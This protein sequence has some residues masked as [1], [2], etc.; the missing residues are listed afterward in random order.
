L[1]IA[2][3]ASPL[4]CD[5]VPMMTAAAEASPAEPATGQRSSFIER[6]SVWIL[7]AIVVLGAIP[8]ARQLSSGTLYPDDAWVALTNHFGLSTSVHMLV[9]SPGFTLFTQWWTGL[10]PTT[11]WFDQLPDLVS[12]IAGIVAVYA[13]IRWNR[14]DRWVALSGAALLAVSTEATSFATHLKPY[15]DDVLLAC[16]LLYAAERC[17]RSMSSRNLAMLAAVAGAC[18]AWSFSSAIVVAGAYLMVTLVWLRRREATA[19]LVLSGTAAMAVI[20][21][22]YLGIVH[23]QTT[24]SLAHYWHEH[25]LSTSSIGS[26]LRSSR[27]AVNGVFGDQLA[28]TPHHMLHLVGRIDEWVLLGLAIAGALAALRQRLLSLCV[29]VV[30]VVCALAHLIPLGSNR[31]DAYLF[32]ALL[33]L[34][35]SGLAWTGRTVHRHAPRMVSTGLSALGIVWLSACLVLN[36]AVPPRYPGGD[37]RHVADVAR[38]M[39]A[40][41]PGTVLLIEGTARWPWA[42]GEDPNVTLIFGQG[43]N[44]GY[45][46]VSSRTS[47]VIMPASS[48]E[49]AFSARWAAT[50]VAGA[51]NL[52][53][54]AYNF[55]GLPEPTLIADALHRDCWV[56]GI[57]RKVTTYT[58]TPWHRLPQCVS[59]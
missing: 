34:I 2:H 55:P 52:V 38:T 19:A 22:I 36:A 43:F 24:S 29:L 32:P 50:H 26:L 16:A 45:A 35:G 21:A 3:T 13:L 23:R 51:S 7:A 57:P 56:P 58:V 1:G 47:V 20:G 11:T 6:R 5:D 8:R 54:V 31:T 44:T 12:S 14:L 39:V 41:H 53:T 28:F 46:P 42:Y 48:A 25:Y 4:I 37:L 10:A 18:A 33:L 49:T 9:T 15:P 17:R 27:R 59:R 40:A 30:V